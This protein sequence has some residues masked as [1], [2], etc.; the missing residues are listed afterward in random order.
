MI[1]IR[2][3]DGVLQYRSRIPT[4]QASGAWGEP[5]VWS[6]W[7]DVPMVALRPQRASAKGE[8]QRAEPEANT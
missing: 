3:L 6:D 7:Q 4:W 5:S 2:W 1:E 8:A